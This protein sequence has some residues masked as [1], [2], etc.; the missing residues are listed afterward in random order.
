LTRPLGEF[1][2]AASSGGGVGGCDVAG[3][4]FETGSGVALEGVH[5]GVPGPSEQHR[6]VGAVLGVV[7]QRRMAQLVQGPPC[8]LPGRGREGCGGVCEQFGRPAPARTLATVDVCPVTG[9]GRLS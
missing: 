4:G 6:G 2:P 5:G 3:E 8:R 1:L 7:G 9:R